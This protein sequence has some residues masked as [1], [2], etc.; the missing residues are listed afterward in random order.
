MAEIQNKQNAEK[1]FWNSW[2]SLESNAKDNGR[3]KSDEP[4]RR[5]DKDYTARLAKLE[6]EAKPSRKP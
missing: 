3:L 5:D 1:E 4:N 6:A 2:G